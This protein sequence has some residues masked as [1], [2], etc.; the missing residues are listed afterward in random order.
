[1]VRI[2]Q[3]EN[4]LLIKNVNLIDVAI[5]RVFN[6]RDITVTG[7]L[8]SSIASHQITS[9]SKLTL[10]E[11][12]AFPGLIDCHVH[13]FE[14]HN[15]KNRGLLLKGEG[16]AVANARARDNLNEALKVGVTC[17]RDMA[18]YSTYNNRLRDSLEKEK[19]NPFR[20]ISCG[21]HITRKD[22]HFWERGVL[23]NP[24][25]KSLTSMVQDE[26]ESGA[27]FIKVMNDDPIFDLDELKEI[28]R[29][30]N[31]KGVKFAC[32]AF[33]DSSLELAISA[34]AHT[35]EHSVPRT[36]E[37]QMDIMGK[38][39][40][41]CPTYTAA[42]DSIEH[43]PCVLRAFK[44][45]TKQEIEDWLKTLEADIPKVFNSST[46][47]ISGTDAGIVPTGFDSLPRE[48]MSYISMGANNLQALQT[49]TL[50]AA[51]ALGLETML[52]SLEVGKS[53][54][55]VISRKNPLEDLGGA[56]NS[57]VVIISRG[58]VV[59]DKIS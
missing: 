5:G 54:D 13:L 21:N 39:I 59:T 44:D 55:I 36:E 48:L 4:G 31:A 41:F 43:L 20:V 15:G 9:N 7:E 6:R 57:I 35:I 11:L 12:W 28:S 8:I 1:M 30:C 19:N 27:D 33:S 51:E 32:H 10:P 26:I 14:I 40:Y 3:I 49:A 38:G 22:G 47:L 46:R 34:G 16:F 58:Q 50:N 25:N 24:E 45:C 2:Y 52:G 29:A 18:S 37:M 42:K 17:V 53:A 56:L 23:Y